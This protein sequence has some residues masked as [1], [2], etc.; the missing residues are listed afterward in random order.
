MTTKGDVVV[1]DDYY[2]YM[3][4]VIIEILQKVGCKATFVT[5][6]DMACSFGNYTSEQPSAQKALINAGVKMIFSQNINAYHDKNIE[7][8]CMYR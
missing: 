4:P 7:L 8:S 1:F 3:G 5:I 2:Y 6:S